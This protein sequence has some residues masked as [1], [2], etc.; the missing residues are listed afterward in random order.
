MDCYRVAVLVPALFCRWVLAGCRLACWLLW[1]GGHLYIKKDAPIQG[2]LLAERFVLS[3]FFGFDLCTW[4]GYAAFRSLSR[5]FPQSFSKHGFSATL[6]PRGRKNIL[7]FHVKV[8]LIWYGF[9]I[10]VMQKNCVL[11]SRFATFAPCKG[12]AFCWLLCFPFRWCLFD[13]LIRFHV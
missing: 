6:L 4:F 10:K 8:A 13:Y 11:M 1:I 2:P 9:H 3:A 5:L 7:L 12:G